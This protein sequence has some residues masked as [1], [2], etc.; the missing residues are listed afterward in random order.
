MENILLELHTVDDVY[1]TSNTGE[2]STISTMSSICGDEVHASGSEIRVSSPNSDDKQLRQSYSVCAEEFTDDI[3]R[4]PGGKEIIG[5]YKEHKS[6]NE[7]LRRRLVNIVVDI[8]TTQCGLHPTT[9]QKV[10]YAK[11]TVDIFHSLRDPST[12][13]GHV[14]IIIFFCC[15]GKKSVLGGETQ[16]LQNFLC[17][18]PY[19]KLPVFFSYFH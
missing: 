4:K 6:L 10:D 17:N 15:T 2:L 3:R 11:A 1:T 9:A 19:H 8:M 16:P 14:R 18:L 5:Y 7:K 13:Y 12:T